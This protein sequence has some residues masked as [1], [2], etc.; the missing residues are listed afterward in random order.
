ML[1]FRGILS[2]V[3]VV[4]RAATANGTTTN[5]SAP[6]ITPGIS[7]TELVVLFAADDGNGG[8]NVPTGMAS[9]NVGVTGAGPNGLVIGAFT[10]ALTAS[11]ATGTL[12]S[13]ANTS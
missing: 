6:S 3:P 12:Q 7:N 10:E 1:D 13:T 2:T 8:I 5:Y 9:A 11:T 4:T